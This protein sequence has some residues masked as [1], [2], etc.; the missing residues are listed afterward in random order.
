MSYASDHFISIENVPF[1]EQDYTKPGAFV[2]F[3][4]PGDKW[5]LSVTGVNLTHGIYAIND[6]PSG[7]G[8]RGY[9]INTPRSWIAQFRYNL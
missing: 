1:E 6:F 9:Y 8:G 3:N 5:S 4:A 2:S 7:L